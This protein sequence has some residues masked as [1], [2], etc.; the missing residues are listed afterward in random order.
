M[1]EIMTILTIAIPTYNRGHRLEKTL[2]DLLQHVVSSGFLSDIEVLVSDNGSPDNTRSIISAQKH[3]FL[4]KGIVFT[5]LDNKKN[6]GFDG[7]IW[8]CYEGAS[9]E[10]VWFLSDDDNLFPDAISN[11]MSELG[12]KS[13]VALYFNFNQKPYD[14]ESPLVK[15]RLEYTT[16]KKYKIYCLRDVVAWPKLTAMVVKKI[17]ISLPRPDINL[18]HYH[19]EIFIRAVVKCGGFVSST[20]FL[21]YPDEDYM[22]HINFPPYV[23]NRLNKQ[24]LNVL[25]DLNL[26]DCYESLCIPHVSPLDSSL[27]SLGASYRNKCKISD[28]LREELWET[29][30]KELRWKN[31]NTSMLWVIL[32]FILSSTVLRRNWKLL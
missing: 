2:R 4:E 9:S 15:S 29:I 22:D 28:K 19:V 21:A 3:F 6:L 18:G 16:K 26:A 27:R 12:R 10:Y 17:E 25:T 14:C 30:F 31:I 23:G 24:L 32:K 20:K 5:H 8:R 1:E 13:T 7:N 11:I